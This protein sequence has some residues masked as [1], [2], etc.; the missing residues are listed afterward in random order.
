MKKTK[1][2][3]EAFIAAVKESY[4]VREVLRRLNLNAT[5]GNYFTF[6]RRVKYLGLD[7]SHFTGKGHLKGKTHNWTKSIP[8]EEALVENSPYASTNNLKLRLLKEGLIDYCCS[9]CGISEWNEKKLSLHLDHINGV[10]HDNRL[11]NLRLLCPN[12]HSQTDTYAGRNIGKWSGYVNRL[13]KQEVKTKVPRMS[14]QPKMCCDCGKIIDFKATRCKSCSGFALV[15][16]KIEWPSVD[17][18]IRM[19]EE[20]SYLAVGKN[21][22]VS[23]NAIRKRIR[24]HKE[25]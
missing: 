8:L 14:R 23:D 3:D 25:R 7:T 22:G 1:T 11:E 10:K 6:H 24:H 21:L 17:E 19:V 9:I 18:L 20:T 12:C 2:T 13:D 15:P 16:T 5:G 4:S